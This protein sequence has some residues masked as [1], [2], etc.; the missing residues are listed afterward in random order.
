MT[1]SHSYTIN[2]SSSTEE[3]KTK[4]HALNNYIY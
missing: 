3:L 2:T 4:Q 1:I